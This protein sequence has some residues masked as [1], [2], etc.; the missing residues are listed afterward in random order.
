MKRGLIGKGLKFILDKN[1][2]FLFLASRG[3][4]DSMDDEEYIKRKY[5]AIFGTELDLENPKTYNQKIQWLK[6]Y[7]RRPDYT[8]YVDKFEV[9]SYVAK[10]IGE[11]HLVPIL[12]VWDSPEDIDFDKLPSKF[13]LKC[14]HNSGLGMC[15]CENKDE[16]QTDRV[17]SGL[18]KGLKQNY[19]LTGREWPYKNVKRRIIAEKFLVDESGVELKDY[20]I[21]CFDGKVRLIMINSDRNSKC[22]TKADYFDEDFNHIDMIWGYEQADITP[23]KP[24]HFEEMKMLAE[25]LSKDMPHVRV[26]FYVADDKV[27]FGEM[28]FFDGSGFEAFEKI[29][30]ANMLGDW[31]KLPAPI[32]ESDTVM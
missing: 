11:E 21:Y 8:K 5:K 10:T 4:Y 23:K 14:N 19:Y 1:Y 2:R 16:L 6:L 7:Y 24:A 26:D 17:I 3:K 25:K 27:Y 30:Y 22:A 18:E 28:T 9:R 12:G 32:E 31:I 15:I 13:V 29:E 20:K